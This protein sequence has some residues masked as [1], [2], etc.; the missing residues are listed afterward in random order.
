M[1]NILIKEGFFLVYENKQDWP[2]KYDINKLVSIEEDIHKI[3]H[4]DKVSVRRNDRYADNGDEIVLNGH[5]FEVEN[6][7]PQYLKNVTDK[8]AREEGYDSL[9]SYKEALTSIHE[10]AVWDPEQLVWAHYLK[11]K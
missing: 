4:G 6:V 5:L 7:Y 9:D 2:K 11:E 3:T 8:N 1:W 10:T